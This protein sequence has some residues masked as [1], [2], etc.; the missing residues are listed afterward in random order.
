[1]EKCRPQLIISSSVNDLKE[2]FCLGRAETQVLAQELVELAGWE[3]ACRW[4]LI[5]NVFLLL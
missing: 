1:M 2:V 3:W 5:A 4:S